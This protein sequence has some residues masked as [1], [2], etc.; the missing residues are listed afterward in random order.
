M[1]VSSITDQGVGQINED[2]ILT[3]KNV[4]GVFDGATSLNKYVDS[5]GKTGGFLAATI[6]KEVFAKEDHESLKDAAHKVNRSLK[7]TMVAA[8]V[9]PTS[10]ADHWRTAAAVVKVKGELIEWLVIADSVVLFIFDDDTFELAT[11]IKSHDTKVLMKWKELAEQEML[12]IRERLINDLIRLRENSLSPQGVL[13]GSAESEK[14]FKT[15]ERPLK[16]VK[17]ILLFTD[18][19][20]PPNEDPRQPTDF[21]Q[22][23]EMF[24]RGGLEEA[25]DTIRSLEKSDPHCWKYPRYKQHDDI[26]AIAITL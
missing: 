24:L 20:F 14:F 19:L 13:N 7:E 21:A 3:S 11:P 23:V 8:G 12:N 26:A 22:I 6:A 17:H 1:K 10:A 9:D 15:G 16:G 2:V 5:D 18:G 25:K 4:L